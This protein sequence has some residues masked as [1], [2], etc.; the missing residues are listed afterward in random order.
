MIGDFEN[1]SQ[2]CLCL[3]LDLLLHKEAAMRREIFDEDDDEY[4][5]FELC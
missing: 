2:D 3:G 5:D 1:H 4:D